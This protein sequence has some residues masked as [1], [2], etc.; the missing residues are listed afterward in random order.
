MIRK[1]KRKFSSGIEKTFYRVVHGYRADNNKIKQRTIKSFGYI[2]DAADKSAFLKEIEN[3]NSEFLN[4]IESKFTLEIP[5][6]A[7]IYDKA[8]QT[9]NYG[10]KY[11]E[12]IYNELKIDQYIN[13]YENEIKFKGEYSLNDILKFLVFSRILSPDSK[14]A[15]FQQKNLYYNFNQDFELHDI[16]RALDHLNDCDQGLQKHIASQIREKFKHD[17]YAYYDLTNYYTSIDYN[18][19]EEGALRQRGVSKERSVSPIV[20]MGLFLDS[21]AIP[22]SMSVFPG[23]TSDSTTLI[24]TITEAKKQHGYK[25]I[26]IVADKGL[27]STKNIETLINQGDGYVFSQILRGTKGKRYHSELFNEKDWVIKNKQ[28]MYKLLTEEYIIKNSSGVKETKERKVLLYW[29]EKDAIRAEKKRQEKLKKAEKAAKNNAYGIKKGAEEYVEEVLCND[30]TGEILKNILRE[31]CVN[32]EKAENDALYDG[33]FCIITSEMEYDEE[34]IRTV[35][36]NLWKIEES[37]KI[38]KSDLYARPIFLSTDSRIKAHFLICYISLIIVRY[39]QNSLGKNCI[40]VER[41][42]DSLN[43]ATCKIFQGGIILLDHVGG[44]IAFHQIV[45]GKGEL[46]NTIKST[47]EDQISSDFKLIQ[48]TYKQP[49]FK[50]LNRQE[51]F[52]KYFKNISL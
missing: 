47:G 3:F 11:L 14:R 15:S 5:I 23:N 9:Y 49:Y 20:Q 37:F 38:M 30:E 48:K 22:F 16:Y 4:N 35:Y 18:D 46:V 2:E 52:N 42:K 44:N 41:I 51:D 7:T 1:D 34:K 29:T 32:Y 50:L 43:A 28:Y 8:F 21:N 17:T 19:E 25:K 40:S 13:K 45:N 26:I 27:N 10:Y 36:S 12:Y 24:P 39:L 33:F 31:K 6:S